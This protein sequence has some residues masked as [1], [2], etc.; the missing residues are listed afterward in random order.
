M[1]VRERRRD[2]DDLVVDSAGRSPA[3]AHSV[4]LLNGDNAERYRHWVSAGVDRVVSRLVGCKQPFTGITPERLAPEIAAVDLDT[5][6]RRR[7]PPPSTSWSGVYLRDA[8]WFHHPRYLAHLNCPVVIPALLGEADAQRGQLLPGHLGPERRGTLIERRLIDWTAARLGLGPDARR[9]L[10]QRRH[11]VQPAGAAARPRGGLPAAPARGRDA[12]RRAA[13]AARLRLRGRHFSVTEVGRAA[14]PRAG[15]GGR[16]RQRPGPADARPTRS[17]ARAR[18]DAVSD[19]L[20]PDGRGRHRRHHRLRQHRPAAGDRRAVRRSACGCTSTPRTAAG[21]SSPARRAP[22]RRHR[23]RRLGHRRL[24][25]VVLPAGQLQRAAGP[26]PV[27]AARTSPTTPTTSTRPH[28]GAAH[29]EPGRQ[30]PADHPPV[31]RAEAVADAARDGRRRRRAR[32]ST[33][34]STG[35]ARPGRCSSADP[36]FDVVVDPSH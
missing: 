24:P 31:R 36:R 27:H 11:P 34:C 5:P 35:P 12:C 23:T 7:R 3:S 30:E 33:R 17:R 21:C 28:G 15:R 8:V 2:L 22:A 4:H 18:R 1:S 16:R 32:S 14:R 19:G 9:R 10:H 25:Q 6:A 29:P 20:S 26:R 13:A